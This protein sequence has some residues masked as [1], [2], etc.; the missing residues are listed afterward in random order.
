MV[1]LGGTQTFLGPLVGAIVLQFLNGA[2]TGYTDHSE[3][4]LGVVILIAVLGLRRG[5]LDFA[6]EIWTRRRGARR[7]VPQQT[8]LVDNDYDGAAFKTSAESGTRD[9]G[10]NK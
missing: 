5:L 2:L 7:T 9:N 1:M 10:E 3:L 8:T 6:N 4:V